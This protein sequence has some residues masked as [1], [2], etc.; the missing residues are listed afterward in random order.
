LKS[1]IRRVANSVMGWTPRPV[2]TGASTEGEVDASFPV[3]LKGGKN[4]TLKGGRILPDIWVILMIT[5]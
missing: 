2:E 3:W 5:L 1:I 4:C